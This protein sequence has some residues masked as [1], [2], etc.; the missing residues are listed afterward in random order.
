MRIPFKCCI[1]SSSLCLLTETYT[2]CSNCGHRYAIQIN[3]CG[4][5]VNERLQLARAMRLDA[6][7]RAQLRLTLREALL[8]K[9]LLDV[10]CGTGK[11]LWHTRAHFSHV[12]G[13][14][15][16][17]KSIQFASSELG[18]EVFN[19][20]RCT[21]GPF[22]V[23]TSWHALEHISAP[24]LV[25]LLNDLRLRCHQNTKV[26]VCVPNPNSLPARLLGKRWG[27][28]DIESHLHEFSR[29]SLDELHRQAGFQPEK[30]HRIFAYNL[31]AWVQSLANLSPLPHNYF[32]YRLK[33][34]WVFGFGRIAL[35][36]RDVLAALWLLPAVVIGT[37]CALVEHFFAREK[38][39]HLVVYRP[40]YDPLS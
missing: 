31:F 18:L 12:T 35:F 25:R 37:G 29:C 23:V 4:V 9:S 26:I 27:F 22:D 11:F 8:Q 1:C 7:T 28:R 19:D 20:V 10:G 5:V 33:R 2:I 6:L 3:I 24:S 14:E 36:T 17:N 39:V 38:S 13:I 21:T 34:G 16:S 40:V 30:S 15:V 32:Y